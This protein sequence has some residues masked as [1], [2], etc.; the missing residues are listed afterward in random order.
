MR[1]FPGTSVHIESLECR[2]LL[3]WSGYAQLVNQDDAA[4]V[5]SSI[6]GQGVTVAVIDTGIDYTHPSLGGGFGP[7]HKVVGGYDLLSNDADPMDTTGHGTNVAGVI[8]ADPFTHNGVTYRGVA[9]DANLVA[10]RVGTEDNISDSNIEKALQWVISNRDTYSIDVV[11]LSL[12]SGFHTDRYDSSRYADEFATLREMGVF[13]VAASGNS[14]DFASGPISQDGIAYPAADPNVFAVGAVTASDV[15][16]S[17]SQRGDELDLLAPGDDI[18]MPKRGGGYETGDGT[19]FASPY[20]AGAAALIRQMDPTATAGDIGS[21]LMTSGVNNRDGVGESGNTTTLQFSRL[22]IAAALQL[23]SG[24]VGRYESL[25]FGTNFS[26]ALDSQGVLHA[27]W[28]D[29]DIGRLLYATRDGQ[30]LW[31]EPI[32]ADAAGD[33]GA[34]PSIAVDLTGKVGVGYF[35][36]TN[37]GVKY[38]QYD[39]RDWSVVMVEHEKHV[40]TNPS[41]A[42]DID[43]NA[44]LAYHKRSGGS[45]RLATL[46]RDAGTW[47]RITVDGAG[48]GAIVGADLSLDVGEAAVGTQFGFTVYDT[49]VAVAYSDSTNGDLKYARLDLDDPTATWYLS[50]V[51]DANGIG[52]VVLDLHDGPLNAGLQAQIIYQDASSADV[53]YAYRNTDWFTETVASTGKLG[54]RAAMYFDQ[55]NSPIAIYYDREKKALY[56]S[57]RATTGEWSKQRVTTSSGPLSVAFNQRT[58]HAALSWLNRPKTDV[59]SMELI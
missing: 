34:M 49:T 45:L 20:V 57:Q 47:G 21:I 46:N 2:R 5:Y 40:G 48:S 18:V 43:G 53:K 25:R 37:T 55:D 17:W 10:L 28:Y 4:S 54:D 56:A 24:R 41:L 59:F 33:V 30:G 39:G 50:L 52:R 27:A 38:A 3:A 13:V 23:T 9:P 35:D 12:G 15:I 36:L 51:D 26:T 42:F 32:V 31:S 29:D 8:A 19:S 58:G 22:D 44:Y 7:G 14:N 1:S 16:T 11:N 6:T